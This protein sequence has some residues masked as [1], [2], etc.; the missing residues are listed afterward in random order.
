MPLDQNQLNVLGT[1]GGDDGINQDDLISGGWLPVPAP[2]YIV[3]E[4][5]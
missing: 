1:D 5:D 4:K 3:Y 2:G